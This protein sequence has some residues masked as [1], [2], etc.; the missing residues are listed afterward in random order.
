M[1]GAFYCT[2]LNANVW[3]VEKKEWTFMILCLYDIFC[4]VEVGLKKKNCRN[5]DFVFEKCW[6]CKRLIKMRIEK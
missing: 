2:F 6:K 3:G 5:V 4:G 1:F